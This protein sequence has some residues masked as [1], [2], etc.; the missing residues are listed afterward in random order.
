MSPTDTTSLLLRLSERDLGILES[1]RAFRLLTTS[2]I[3]RLHF[4]ESHASLGAAAGATMRVLTRLESH[5]L[6]S[7][8]T[9]R[10]GGVRAGSSGITWQLGPTGER[11]LRTMHGEEKRRRYIE[12]SG[13]FAAHTLE[14]A[15]LAIAVHEL[16]DE[17]AV[18]LVSV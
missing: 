7:R 9:R 8:L 2:Q 17:G 3:R 11:L 12:P 10:I 4:T 13:A 18:E 6:A 5:K 15:E 1:L 14:V 16:R